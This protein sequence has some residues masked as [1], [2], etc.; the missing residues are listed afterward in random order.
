MPETPFAPATRLYVDRP[1]LVEFLRR[2]QAS[3]PPPGR[4]Y[5]VGETVQLCEG[6]T[7][8]ARCLEFAVE[9]D[10]DA[11]PGFTRLAHRLAAGLGIPIV[12]ESPAE[13]IPL[14]KGYRDRARPTLAQADAPGPLDLAYFDPYSIAFRLVARGDEPDYRAVLAFLQHGWITVEAMNALLSGLLPQFSKETIAQDPAEFRRKYRGLL[15]MW[16]DHKPPGQESRP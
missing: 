15:Q 2:L 3:S 11:H 4:L 13:V 8:R 5:L 12:E 14:P 9:I 16:R 10:P 1:T 6:W 7:P